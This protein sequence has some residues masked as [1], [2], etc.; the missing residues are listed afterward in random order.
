M[1]GGL[2]GV[3]MQK[4]NVGHLEDDEKW[5]RFDAT[6]FLKEGALV[7]SVIGQEYDWCVSGG[8]KSG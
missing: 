1:G 3:L 8:S 2:S 4:R 7:S 5:F 6:F